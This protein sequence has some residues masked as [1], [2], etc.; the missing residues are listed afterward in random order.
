MRTITFLMAFL[1]AFFSSSARA[2]NFVKCP[3]DICPNPAS[4]PV[5]YFVSM[6]ACGSACYEVPAGVPYSLCTLMNVQ[7]PDPSKPVLKQDIEPCN[8]PEHCPGIVGSKVCTDPSGMKIWR[9]IPASNPAAYEAYCAVTQRMTVK[10]LL[11]DSVKV[12][13]KQA[14][15]QASATEHAAKQAKRAARL[16][17]LVQCAKLTVGTATRAQ[18]D[19]C[20]L[21]VIREVVRDRL[22][23]SEQ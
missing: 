4:E 20:N 13:A 9:Q 15:D 23:S 16:P 1:L 18:L 6:E 3:S 11:I 19:A 7:V 22:L 17:I 5:R 12:A 2:A 8:G 14:A 10:K 21:Q